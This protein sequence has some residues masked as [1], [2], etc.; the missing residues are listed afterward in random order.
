MTEECTDSVLPFFCLLIYCHKFVN[1]RAYNS[2][3]NM[4]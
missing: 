1:V 4:I 2:E 3:N